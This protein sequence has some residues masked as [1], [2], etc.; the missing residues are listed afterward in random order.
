MT[1]INHVLR[2]PGISLCR[3]L[4]AAALCL[5]SVGAWASF[6]A[7][8]TTPPGSC[9]TAP[10]YTYSTGSIIDLASNATGPYS[11]KAAACD[12]SAVMSYN[13]YASSSPGWGPYTWGVNATTPSCVNWLKDKNGNYLGGGI[14]TW[15]YAT[16][17]VPAVTPSYSCPAGSTL[18]GTT[19]TCNAGN[20]ENGS[21]C[22]VANGQYWAD[23]LN[24][25]DQT[26]AG[27]GGCGVSRCF[28]GF[29]ITASGGTCWKDKTTGKTMYENYGP[30]S[31]ANVPC[32]ATPTGGGASKVEPPA[33]SSPASCS[34][35]W[36][37]VNGVDTCVPKGTSPGTGTATNDSKSTTTTD[38]TGTTTTTRDG[39]TV[40]QGGTC[41]TT[42][43]TTTTAPG[44]TPQTVTSSS[45]QPQVSFCQENP[46]A[47]ACQAPDPCQDNPDSV[48]CMKSGTPTND[49]VLPVL[50]SGFTSIGSVVF[51]S[52]AGCPA[53]LPFT[54]LDKTYSFSYASACS[55]AASYGAPL[56][57]VLG[58]ALAAFV[59]VGGFK[60]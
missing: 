26:L 4:A 25:L 57:L 7:T 6:P 58:A 23:L 35:Y 41:T 27:E 3:W 31:S 32:T 11:T 29:T 59:F 52:T 34:G 43:T 40:C 14:K 46:S 12:A 22:T 54:V 5:F 53:D 33:T 9:T 38:S 60:V 10:C 28:Q 36:G 17:S 24:S 20:V 51:T 18:T 45:S 56:V 30:Y 39:V 8:D 44:V 1:E 50:N 55:T 15:S 48:A 16:Q 42:R 2:S 47:K 13:Y 49:Q 37:S 19:C 21:S